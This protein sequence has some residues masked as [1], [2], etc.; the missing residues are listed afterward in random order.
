MDEGY[1]S[2]FSDV[3]DYFPHVNFI[4]LSAKEIHLSSNGTTA[5]Y[6]PI[7]KMLPKV[8]LFNSFKFKIKKR[9]RK[10]KTK[11]YYN[12]NHY[13]KTIKYKKIYR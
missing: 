10:V 3:S 11:T 6:R 7:N 2:D 4:H 8:K 1:Q 12:N 9:T 5:Y 13:C